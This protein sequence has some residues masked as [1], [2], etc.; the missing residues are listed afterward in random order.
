MPCDNMVHICTGMSVWV[1]LYMKF[2]NQSGVNML[3]PSFRP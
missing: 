1:W 2:S 3:K